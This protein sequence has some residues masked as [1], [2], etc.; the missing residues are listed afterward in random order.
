M[1]VAKFSGFDINDFIEIIVLYPGRCIASGQR[2]VISDNI[3]DALLDEFADRGVYPLSVARCSSEDITINPSNQIDLFMASCLQANFLSSIAEMRKNMLEI[4]ELK[5]NTYPIASNFR[6]GFPLSRKIVAYMKSFQHEQKLTDFSEDIW[7][8]DTPQNIYGTTKTKAQQFPIQVHRVDEHHYTQ[9]PTYTSYLNLVYPKPKFGEVYW[10]DFGEP[11]GN[12]IPF[13]R[14][15][16]VIQ[17]DSTLSET[18]LVVPSTSQINTELDSTLNPIIAL[19]SNINVATSSGAGQKAMQ[20]PS[21]LLFSQMRA[22]DKSRLRKYLFTFNYDFLKT[23][24][25]QALKKLVE[26]INVSS[27]G[28]PRKS[29]GIKINVRNLSDNQKQILA[30]TKLPAYTKLLNTH[31][32]EALK[33]KEFLIEAYGFDREDAALE[34]VI[35]S[36]RYALHKKEYRFNLNEYACTQKGS[37][38]IVVKHITNL[39]RKVFYK[40]PKLKVSEFISLAAQIIGGASNARY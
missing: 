17:K 19:T 14:P 39:V 8:F 9:I 2:L 5:T 3:A 1:V 28:I 33:I 15:A 31:L 6:A 12:E 37:Y 21:Q 23:R 13:V 26:G 16:V 40:Y 36:V 34:L 30:I 38:D 20:K 4:F 24:I 25:E 35:D 32:P 10:V 29:N 18:V 7:N 11:Y 27:A 22:V